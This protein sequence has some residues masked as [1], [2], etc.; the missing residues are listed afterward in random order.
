MD[1]FADV[2]DSALA[3]D[4]ENGSGDDSNYTGDDEVHVLQQPPPQE[5]PSALEHFT[6]SQD[7]DFQSQVQ[8]VV[9]PIAGAG[10][11]LVP[12]P[13]PKNIETEESTCSIC[14]EPWTNSGTHRLVSIKC[15]HLFGE[16]C[17][18]KWIAQH[19]REGV[20]KCPEC[21]HPAKRKDVRRIW[22]KSVVV[23]DTVEK[24]EAYSRVKKE[25][26]LR[27]RCEK[28][29]AHSKMAYEMLKTEMTKLQKKF[30]R[31]RALKRRYRLEV[32]QLKS[33][34]PEA[35]IAKKFSYMPLRTIPVSAAGI[36]MANY[37]SYRQDEEMLVCSRQINNVY[38][39]AKVSM[40]DYSNNLNAFIPIHSQA[41][42]DVQCYPNSFAN[43]S[44]V[45]TAS[46]DK[47]LK[48]SSTASQQVVLT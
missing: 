21:N 6:P 14:F 38:G 27:M 39:L 40:R 11:S 18:L 32:R 3:S 31:Q 41:I 42:R 5:A 33:T 28:D 29:L 13:R 4:I 48:I 20:V 47:T 30:D 25:L 10:Q 43:K 2:Q 15:G 23:L 37:L 22:S 24:E 17:I 46:M 16:N 9:R 45:L 36:G 8:V 12:E 34:N 26:E 7:Q 1:D 19:S 35:A 44:L